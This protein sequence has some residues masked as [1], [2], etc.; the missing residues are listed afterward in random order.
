MRLIKVIGFSPQNILFFP[1]INLRA[2]HITVRTAHYEGTCTMAVSGADIALSSMT[3]E[4]R[5]HFLPVRCFAVH[6]TLV[7]HPLYFRVPCQFTQLL[8]LRSLIICWTLFG[9]FHTSTVPRSSNVT[10]WNKTGRLRALCWLRQSPCR[11]LLFQT[12]WFICIHLSLFCLQTTRWH[13]HS[14]GRE[15]LTWRW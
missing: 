12:T 7:L 10:A 13:T 3:A 2:K 11:R 14:R 5:D 9:W 1:V 6:P 15:N 8:N 4:A